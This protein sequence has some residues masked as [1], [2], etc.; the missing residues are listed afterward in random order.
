MIHRSQ[1]GSRTQTRLKSRLSLAAN[2]AVLHPCILLLESTAMNSVGTG[3][4]AFER[5]LLNRMQ[6]AVTRTH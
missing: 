1:H 3:V 6:V 2:L 4:E 5:R